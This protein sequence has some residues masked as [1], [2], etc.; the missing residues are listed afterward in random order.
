M[1]SAQSRKL[2]RNIISMDFLRAVVINA[3]V[4]S[5]LLLLF[6]PTI[7]SD[8]YDTE[9]VIYGAV[10][11]KYSSF[12]M[13]PTF[14]FGFIIK[15]LLGGI[16]KIP[17]YI[18]FQYL[19]IFFSFVMIYISLNIKDKKSLILIMGCFFF[20]G[21]ELYIRFTFSKTA[22]FIIVAGLLAILRYIENEDVKWQ[23]LFFSL[24]FIIIGISIRA[25]MAMIVLEVFFSAVIINIA[26]NKEIN[27]KR[28]FKFL[29]LSIIIIA[30]R[31]GIVRVDNTVKLDGEW[32][33]YVLNNFKRARLQD[34]SMAD[35][36]KYADQYSEAGISENDYILFKDWGLYNDYDVFSPTTLAKIG[37]FNSAN[38]VDS[39]KDI[40]EKIMK[41]TL[42]YYSGETSFYFFVFVILWLIIANGMDMK[43]KMII[44]L[45]VI[46]NCFLAYSYMSYKGRLQHHVDVI[47][48]IAG[49]VLL[50]YYYQSNSLVVETKYIIPPYI[51]LLVFLCTF[52]NSLNNSSY[53]DIRVSNQNIQYKKNKK[54]MDVF[55][56]DKKH[57]YEFCTYDT[58]NLYDAVFT[59]FEIIPRS[60]YS[61]LDISNRYYIP[62]WMEI[63][64][65][66]EIDN[67]YAEATNSEV[68]M[69][70]CTDQNA[71]WIEHLQ[72][73]INEHYSESAVFV[74]VRKVGNVNVY[75][76]VDE[77]FDYEGY[78]SNSIDGEDIEYDINVEAKDN[79]VH[80]EGYAYLNGVDSY[81]QDVCFEM[82]DNTDLSRK[83]VFA[84][85][86]ESNAKADN[87]D[88][89]KY[90]GVV[91]DI[92][93][94]TD[95]YSIWMYIKQ[96]YEVYKVQIK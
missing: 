6:E 41:N 16:S 51:V 91:A 35:Y 86:E 63:S 28:L 67:I 49:I 37:D 61:N 34:Y 78:L 69:F 24:I 74:R 33:Q 15:L 36:Y 62:D 46:I 11:G 55:S 10:N 4:L 88:D 5:I 95:N 1:N 44:I 32:S 43:K 47:V 56:G 54:I 83:Y 26:I 42:H 89:V 25:A 7:K 52:Y 23:S 90:S 17:W 70:A 19:L 40:I 84:L 9:M 79:V 68:I 57:M 93:L 73:Y 82:V 39:L 94:E 72:K 59:P 58:N 45:P 48:L 92:N 31:N 30:F 65:S 22:G 71:K 29:I 60:Y 87:N 50:L 8:D 66:Y 12:S 96:G 53:Y 3:I 27:K 76:F 20:I 81:T 13:Y 75:R 64:K 21:Y 80:L 18:V 38:G 14:F 77:K 2:I 85:K